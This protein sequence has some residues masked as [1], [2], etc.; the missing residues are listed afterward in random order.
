MPTLKGNRWAVKLGLLKDES[1]QLAMFDFGCWKVCQLLN[2]IPWGMSA[3]V[4]FDLFFISFQI[5][6]VLQ[7]ENE[8]KHKLMFKTVPSKIYLADMAH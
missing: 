3:A 6:K 2:V 5:S 7:V 8:N 4:G 1:C